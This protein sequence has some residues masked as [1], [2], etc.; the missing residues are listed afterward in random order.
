MKIVSVGV[1]ERLHRTPFDLDNYVNAMIAV[2]E[3][4]VQ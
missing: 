1:G 3:A 4:L 2:A